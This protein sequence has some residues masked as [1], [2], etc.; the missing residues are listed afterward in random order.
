ML[1]CLPS[2]KLLQL[3]VQTKVC[4]C[5]LKKRLISQ[6]WAS[7]NKFC[8][9]TTAFRLQQNKFCT[10]TTTRRLQQNKF[11]TPTTARQLQQNKFCTPASL[12]F[13]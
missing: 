13:I 12:A 5:I 2:A 7:Q 1:Y 11:C 9:P 6:S 8:T 10:P 4:T 3:E